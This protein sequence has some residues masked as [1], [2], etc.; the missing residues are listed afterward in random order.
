MNIVSLTRLRIPSLP[1]FRLW[2]S[3]SGPKGRVFRVAMRERNPRPGR[4][5]PE[6]DFFA[7]PFWL[8]RIAVLVPEVAGL[9]LARQAAS[10]DGGP[11]PP[12]AQPEPCARWNCGRCAAAACGTRD[13]PG[14]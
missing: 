11:P 12:P 4:G 6:E 9:L 5:M 14:K 2:V 10:A 8:A 3:G 13:A 7:D 1:D